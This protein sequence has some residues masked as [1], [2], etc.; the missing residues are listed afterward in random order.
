V[1]DLTPGWIVPFAEAARRCEQDERLWAH[2]LSQLTD[3]QRRF[4][5]YDWLWQAH[6]GQQEPRGEWRCWLLMA[7]RGFGKTRTGAEW[8]HRVAAGNPAA[9]IALVGET[10]EEAAR[11]MVEGPSGILA[12]AKGEL[13]RWG[14]T[15]GELYWPNGAMGFVYSAQAAEA[16]RGPEHDAAWCDELAKWGCN[17][18]IAWD[19]L[20]LGLRR[21]DC[22]RVLVTTTPR[23]NPLL[24]RIIAAEGTAVTGGRTADNVHLP[25]A[26]QKA[27]LAAY[28]GT[29]LGAQEL[30][31]RLI[32]AIEGS[33]FPPEV[34]ER[35]RTLP[36]ADFKRVVIGVDPPA[37]AQGDAC[38]IVACAVDRLEP[39]RFHILADCSVSGLRPEGWA[40]AVANAAA[41]WSADR[42]VAEKNQGGEMVEAVLRGA[43]CTLPVRLVHASRG[44]AARAE[45][46]A[47]LMEAGR[48]KLAGRFP[49]LEGELGG[50]TAGGYEGPTR[51]PDRAD[52]CVWAISSLIEGARRGAPKI[53]T[54]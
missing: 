23:P 53:L 15:K 33:L 4:L 12:T 39:P 17:G 51:S 10:R 54:L 20:M 11:V 44:K 2:F 29:R 22:P 24:K 31:G 19:N 8:T 14:A 34:L 27:M 5:R 13:P 47:A 49:E 40:R 50:L 26:F 41:A 37:S 46:V 42:I 9:R 32:E 28:G 6:R 48:V 1:T 52:A 45:P 16:L 30:E 43:D 7:G 3:P 35:A 21:G 18:E 38:G 36:G 25:P